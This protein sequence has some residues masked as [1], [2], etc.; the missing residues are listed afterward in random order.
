[1][2]KSSQWMLVVKRKMSCSLYIHTI[3]C[4]IV[5]GEKKLKINAKCFVISIVSGGNGDISQK[6]R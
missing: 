4:Y 3:T 6:K 1:M 2:E 5:K